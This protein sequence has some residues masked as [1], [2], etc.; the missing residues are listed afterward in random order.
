[1]LA[2]MAEVNQPAIQYHFG[3]KEGLYRAVVQ[4]IADDV[5]DR[6]RPTREQAEAVM[7][8]PNR[9]GSSMR[10]A[11]LDILDAFTTIVL[12]SGG[13]QGW[14]DFIARA[15]IENEAMLEALTK[16]MWSNVVEPSAA[17]L[18]FLMEESDHERSVLAALAL[19]G[20]ITTFKKR[21]FQRTI[22][23]AL[24]W[25]VFGAREIAV[26][27]QVVREQANAFLQTA[28]RRNLP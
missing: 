2:E 4:R 6:M 16:A 25:T 26:I 21:C 11:L 23:Q 15:E 20:T 3:S 14:A 22:S 27:Q 18:G 28:G 12:V 13:H 1:M 5:S 19:L 8:A 17:L 10:S 24:G 7:A 9:S